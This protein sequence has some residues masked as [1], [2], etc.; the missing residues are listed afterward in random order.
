MSCKESKM[1]SRFIFAL[2]SSVLSLGATVQAAE[3]SQPIIHP[4]TELSP[5]SNDANPTPAGHAA[6][7]SASPYA[8]APALSNMWVYAVG[9]TNCD[10]EYTSGL[11]TTAC[12]HGGPELR[13]AVLEIGY[14]SNRVAW[15]IGGLLPSSA[16][17]ESTLVCVTGGYYTWPC[18]AGQTAVGFLNKYRLDGHQSGQFKYQNTSS[19]APFNTMSVQISIK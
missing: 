12:D 7:S 1:K 16:M 17:Y 6:I 3:T 4:I 19:N 15:M 8:P 11:S 10:W 5:L 9:S 2:V 18:S 13:V 14:G